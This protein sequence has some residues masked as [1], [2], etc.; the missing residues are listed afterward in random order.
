MPLDVVHIYIRPILVAHGYETPAFHMAAPYIAYLPTSG[1]HNS[2]LC[3]NVSSLLMRQ[4]PTRSTVSN[5]HHTLDF[6]DVLVRPT[7]AVDLTTPTCRKVLTCLLSFQGYYIYSIYEVNRR[8][9]CTLSE[10]I[11]RVL[12]WDK[13][14]QTFILS[15]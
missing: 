12:R 2:R 10:F 14:Y 15:P 11:Y 8:V 9:F 3:A 1:C 5:R 7:A 4:K 6:A 13:H